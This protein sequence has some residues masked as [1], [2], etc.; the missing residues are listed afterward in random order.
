MAAQP[1]PQSFS[2][3][4]NLDPTMSRDVTE[5]DSPRTRSL[6]HFFPDFTR[7]TGQER[8]PGTRLM[9]VVERLPILEIDGI[10]SKQMRPDYS[11]NCETCLFNTWYLLNVYFFFTFLK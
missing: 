2:A 5:R 1:S 8:T 11:Q 10:K 9:A 7:T 4:S 6:A 3:R